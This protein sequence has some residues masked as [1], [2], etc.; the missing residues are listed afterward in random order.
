MVF[1]SVLLCWLIVVIIGVIGVIYGVW[2]F[3][4]LCV[5]GGVEIY[6]LI[7]NVGWFNI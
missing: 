2:L 6:L 1:F 5:V 7:L 4:L 3:D